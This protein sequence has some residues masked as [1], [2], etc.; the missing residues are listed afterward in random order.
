M[1]KILRGVIPAAVLAAALWWF[2][3][4]APHDTAA[5]TPSVLVTT[6]TLKPGSLPQTITAYGTIAAG[7]GAE[8][9][10]TMPASGSMDAIDVMPG[11][12]VMGGAPLLHV[13]PDPQAVADLRKANSA[14][15]AAKANRAHVA[16]LFAARLATSA[17]LAAADQTLRDATS[18]LTALQTTNTGMAFTLTAP[19]AGTI[20]AVSASTGAMLPAGTTL[21]RIVKTSGLVAAVAAPAANAAAL[22]PGDGALV[23]LLGSHQSLP[24]KVTAVA[25]MIDPQTGLI[26]ITIAPDGP[27][28]LGAA[29]VAD[30]T[31]GTLS[32]YVLPR[33][34]VQTDDHRAY[35]FQIDAKNI[36]HRQ[37]VKILGNIGNQT[38]VA[39]NLNTAMPVVITGAYQLD[40]GSAVRTGP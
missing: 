26:G 24:G 30:I 17:D 14:V 15:V 5:I 32:G 37:D 3:P 22:H 20:T 18:T 6:I 13:Q 27:V 34:A 7:P 9:T 25:T 23:S 33:D 36:A 31:T 16:A 39:P 11:Q 1:N 10:I 29:V 19:F 2:W 38:I 35:V 4:S 28:T 21:L 40:D 12:A 8:T